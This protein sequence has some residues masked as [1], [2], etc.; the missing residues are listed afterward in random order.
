MPASR[1]LE[2][3][4]ITTRRGS[5]TTCCCERP[6]QVDH[7]GLNGTLRHQLATEE[8]GEVR[9][10]QA[11]THPMASAVLSNVFRRSASPP[12]M[13]PERGDSLIGAPELSGSCQNEHRSIHTGSPNRTACNA[14]KG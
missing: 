10:V 13:E 9:D 12:W 8:E 3:T 7:L 11:V 2:A 4:F 1:G 6:S 14:P 5:S